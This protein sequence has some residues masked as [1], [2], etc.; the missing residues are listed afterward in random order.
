MKNYDISNKGYSTG[1]I[2]RSKEPP[3]I[4][5]GTVACLLDGIM[6]EEYVEEHKNDLR[7]FQYACCKNTY[8]KTEYEEFDIETKE[9]K[10]IPLQGIDRA[11]AL[12]S[13]H[14]IGM[15]YKV[16]TSKNPTSRAKVSNLPESVFIYN[17]NILNENAYI[18]LK[19][20]IDYN[21]YV[22]RIYQKISQFIGGE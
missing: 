2:F 14:I 6:P 12:K 3:I 5:Q 8:K 1:E 4:S 19:D 13:N 15:V 21:Y 18:E 20:K 22:K 11:F 17:D 16:G 7:L 9:K 10:I